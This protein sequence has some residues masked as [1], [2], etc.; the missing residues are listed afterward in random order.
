MKRVCVCIPVCVCH[1]YS[2]YVRQI[3]YLI[4]LIREKEVNSIQIPSFYILDLNQH[5]ICS[6]QPDLKRTIISVRHNYEENPSLLVYWVV[7][8]PSVRRRWCQ[9][10][11]GVFTWVQS[12][13][14]SYHSGIDLFHSP[15]PPDPALNISR[16]CV[17]YEKRSTNQILWLSS[18]Y[19]VDNW[20]PTG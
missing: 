13:G 2:F 10:R 8:Q 16:H 1:L 19:S 15:V 14:E 3:L 5:Q 17:W 4:M 18:H 12:P 7:F 9:G 20:T 11:G 6:S